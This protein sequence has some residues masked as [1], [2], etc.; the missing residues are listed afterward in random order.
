M[1]QMAATPPR[2]LLDQRGR[3]AE[4]VLT[5]QSANILEVS[6]ELGYAVQ[7][8]DSLGNVGLHEPTD[9]VEAA[10]RC[11]TWLRIF[12]SRFTIPPNTSQ[13]VRVLLSPP[14]DLPAGEYWARL[15]LTGTPTTFDFAV[16]SDT[17]TGIETRI[18]TSIEL[19]L[20]VIF[21]TGEI[22][23]SVR[24]DVAAVHRSTKGGLD[25]VVE[26]IRGGNAAYRG[27]MYGELVTKEG[28]TV[29]QTS[30]QFTT[31]F[32]LSRSLSFPAVRS[33]DYLLRL[34]AV[35]EK[36]GSA[37]DVVIPSATVEKSFGIRITDTAASLLP[38]P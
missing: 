10:R 14:A 37:M 1:A 20:P 13:T 12:P 17:V 9:S 18:R 33:G 3:S 19:D 32:A 23:T 35:T 27:T 26:T 29:A 30:A 34:R 21:R 24:F 11:D 2:L 4:V 36:K 28:L 5:N 8:S 6:T 31:E 15:R 16:S 22:S 25:V 7:F 38:S